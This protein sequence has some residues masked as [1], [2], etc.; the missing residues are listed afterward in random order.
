MP[1]CLIP[2]TIFLGFQKS[3]VAVSGKGG[4]ECIEDFMKEDLNFSQSLNITVSIAPCE[5]AVMHNA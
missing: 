4:K 5:I 2:H 1:V 3:E